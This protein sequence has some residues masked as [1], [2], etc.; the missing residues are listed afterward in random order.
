MLQYF[1][2]NIFGFM[3]QLTTYALVGLTSPVVPSL[4]NNFKS[5]AVI[6]VGAGTGGGGH[7]LSR[8][9]IFGYCLTAMASCSYTCLGN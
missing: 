9:T 8:P 7:I 3:L 6:A 2:Q 4:V 1:Q 5:V